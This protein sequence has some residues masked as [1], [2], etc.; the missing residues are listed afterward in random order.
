MGLEIKN[1][2]D[3]EAIIALVKNIPKI[4]L[5]I[6]NV[7]KISID[8]TTQQKVPTEKQLKEI[9]QQKDKLS[10]AEELYNAFN[11]PTEEFKI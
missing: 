2:K 10:P 5:E 1:Y 6:P 11:T 9:N 4:D 3:L 8:N 7:I